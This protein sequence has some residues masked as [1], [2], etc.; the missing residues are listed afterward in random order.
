ME[1]N[2]MQSISELF[3]KLRFRKKLIGGI[4]ERDVWRKLDQVQQAYRSAYEEQRI[5]CK[6]ILEMNGI[7]PGLLDED[8]PGY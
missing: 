3:S 5:R 2:D 6:T 7:D 4:D 1:Y 8:K